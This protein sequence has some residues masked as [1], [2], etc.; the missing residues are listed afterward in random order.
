MTDDPKTLSD[1]DWR[2]KLSPEQYHVL[3]EAGTERA[4]TGQYDKHYD[5]GEYACAGCGTVLF[6]SDSKYNSGCGWPAFTKPAQDET[7]EEKR[8]VSFG[9]IRTE[10]LCSNCGGH[11]GHVFPDGPPEAGG[12]RY[13]INSAA[14]DFEKD[15]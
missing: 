5:E 3:R 4:F 15:G 1:D 12:M 14:L 6:S 9:M 2:K 10:V 11:L 7:V 13:C 8:D